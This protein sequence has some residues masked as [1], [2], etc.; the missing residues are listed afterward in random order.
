MITTIIGKKNQ[1]NGI[2]NA[3]EL[4]RL[5]IEETAEVD[6]RNSLSTTISFPWTVYR[7]QRRIGIDFF[8]RFHTA[9]Q[10]LSS[11]YH[12]WSGLG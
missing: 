1:M 5:T 10:T 4:E 8:Q 6:E 11:T 12:R 9:F 7:A 2:Y 3:T